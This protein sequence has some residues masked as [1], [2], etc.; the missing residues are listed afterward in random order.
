M[1]KVLDSLIL[2]KTQEIAACK[3]ALKE[4]K[5]EVKDREKMVDKFENLSTR[6]LET[7]PEVNIPE[8]NI[9]NTNKK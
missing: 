8:V 5:L 6:I 3:W 9:E 2:T 4:M 1:K 7:Y